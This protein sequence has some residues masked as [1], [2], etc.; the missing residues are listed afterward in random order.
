MNLHYV[1]SK[2][3]APLLHGKGNGGSECE[4][5]PWAAEAHGPTLILLRTS[6]Y[7]ITKSCYSVTKLYLTLGNTMDCSM[8]G[9]PVFHYLLEFDQIQVH[10]VGDEI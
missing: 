10:W 1:M 8:P 2:Q 5:L 9:F 3:L 4:M 7:Y 6:W